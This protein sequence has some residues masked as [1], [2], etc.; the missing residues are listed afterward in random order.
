ML[1]SALERTPL[2]A[3]FIECI[4]IFA[5]ST[6]ARP[7]EQ[8][9]ETEL[10]RYGRC[11]DHLVAVADE[12]FVEAPISLDQ[13][14]SWLE[15]QVATNDHEDEPYDDE[16]SGIVAIT[17]HK[18]KGR[19]FDKVFVVGSTQFQLSSKDRSE[20]VVLKTDEATKVLWRWF[21]GSLRFGNAGRSAWAVND[22]ETIRE[23]TRLLYVAMTRA[24]Q[25]LAVV[26]PTSQPSATPRSWADL[27]GG[28]R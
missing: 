3:W 8:D 26:V 22:E 4:H 7:G 5:P 13:L 24:K 17:V 23:E 15:L 11:L 21:S 18:A 25:N 19:E 12:T 9:A 1:A 20:A 6:R 28:V 14:I 10:Q 2:L 16:R 27:I